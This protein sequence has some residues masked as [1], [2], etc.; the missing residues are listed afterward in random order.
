MTAADKRGGRIADPVHVYVD[1]TWIERLILDNPVAQRLRYIR[2]NG[3]G[4]LVFPEA[5]SSRFAHSLGSMHL[6]SRFLAALLANSDDGVRERLSDAI[7]QVVDETAGAVSAYAP[8]VAALPAA[9]TR[10][11]SSFLRLGQFGPAEAHSA[12]AVVH[13]PSMSLGCVCAAQSR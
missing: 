10:G 1:F 13:R 2:Q 7:A 11:P 3:L 12:P 8:S 4:H 5:N 9:A 6:A